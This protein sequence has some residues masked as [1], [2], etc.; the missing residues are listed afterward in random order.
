MSH[1]VTHMIA[2]KYREKPLSRVWVTAYRMHMAGLDNMISDAKTLHER[3]RVHEWKIIKEEVATGAV[4]QT[5]ARETVRV[6][7]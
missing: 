4:V 2:L 3:K 6:T 1:H 5:M 7:A